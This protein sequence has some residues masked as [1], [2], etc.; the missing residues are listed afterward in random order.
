M[1]IGC[2]VLGHAIVNS[3]VEMTK[4]LLEMRFSLF[5]TDYVLSRYFLM[6][7]SINIFDLGW[8]FVTSLGSDV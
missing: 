5:E 6:S 1:Q 7:S 8:A 2:G 3:R 4:K